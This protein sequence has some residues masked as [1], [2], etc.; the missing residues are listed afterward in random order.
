MTPLGKY[1]MSESDL[2]RSK[3]PTLLLAAGAA[4]DNDVAS[5][6]RSNLNGRLAS[7]AL[8]K[9]DVTSWNAFAGFK[10]LGAS[11]QTEYHRR[12]IDPVRNNFV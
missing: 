3:N 9:S 10:W 4:Y 8:G 6:T 1:S 12:K 5:H 2:P 7:T 11:V